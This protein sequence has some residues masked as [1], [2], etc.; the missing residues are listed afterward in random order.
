MHFIPYSAVVCS[1]LLEHECARESH[2]GRSPLRHIES[3][4]AEVHSPCGSSV[5]LQH[6]R[7]A[8]AAA[9]TTRARGS[10]SP[11]NTRARQQQQPLQ[12]ARAAAAAALTTRARGSSSPYNTRARQQQ[13]LQ[14]ARA[15]AAALTVDVEASR[16]ADGQ[17]QPI[18]GRIFGDVH[19]LRRSRLS[20]TSGIVRH[21]RFAVEGG[22]TGSRRDERLRD[23]CRLLLRNSARRFVVQAAS[24]R[25]MIRNSIGAAAY[26]RRN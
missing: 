1:A 22:G 13:P 6:K 2:A 4:I 11:Y 23:G 18:F 8:A 21:S 3:C 24:S 26:C 7:A 12:H 16:P 19:V 15:A 9:L 20:G 14:H 10:S 17:R 25:Q 5:T